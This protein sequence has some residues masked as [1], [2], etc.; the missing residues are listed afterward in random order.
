MANLNSVLS[1]AY[2][3][4]VSELENHPQGEVQLSGVVFTSDISKIYF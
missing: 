1:G 4:L 3:A 2:T